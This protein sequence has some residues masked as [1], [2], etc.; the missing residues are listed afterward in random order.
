MHTGFGAIFKNTFRQFWR[1][2]RGRMPAPEKRFFRPKMK[3]VAASNSHFKNKIKLPLHIWH[4]W[5]LMLQW[6]QSQT[7][8]TISKY[9]RLFSGAFKYMHVWKLRKL[10]IVCFFDFLSEVKI[11]QYEKFYY[12]L[13]LR[14]I[15][16]LNT[17]MPV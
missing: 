13:L 15:M 5:D 1:A 4:I 6:V 7:V 3:F 2:A 10:I 16:N 14:G 17:N 8:K 9:L 12:T 11:H